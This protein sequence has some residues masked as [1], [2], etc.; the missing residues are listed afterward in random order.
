MLHIKTNALFL[1]TT[2]IYVQ[3]ILTLLYKKLLIILDKRASSCPTIRRKKLRIIRPTA[4][5][6]GFLEAAYF[7]Q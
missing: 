2:Y 7:T 4:A 6:G 1:K 5:G 3:T